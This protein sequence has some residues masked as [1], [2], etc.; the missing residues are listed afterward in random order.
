MKSVTGD[1]Y[2]A[3]PM[4]PVPSNFT[5][6]L[7]VMKVSKKIIVHTKEIG[8][9]YIPMEIYSSSTAPDMSV[10]NEDEKF[11]LNRVVSIYGGLNGKQ[12]EDLTHAEA[13]WNGVELKNII[14]YELGFYRETDFSK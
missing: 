8:A 6:I 4:G 5:N 12:L 9:E 11:I 2:I 7:D 1:S 13:P 10:F 14:P 3:L